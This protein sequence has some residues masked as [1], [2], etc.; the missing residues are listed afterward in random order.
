MLKRNFLKEST[1]GNKR[2]IAQGV[3]KNSA[4]YLRYFLPP[5]TPQ[6]VTHVS[7]SS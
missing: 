4:D 1:E 3:N 6:T 2:K 7:I 5:R